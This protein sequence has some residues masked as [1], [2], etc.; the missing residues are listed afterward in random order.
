MLA[1]SLA[2]GA[3]GR[4]NATNALSARSVTDT[5]AMF[6][7]LDRLPGGRAGLERK[8]SIGIK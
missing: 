3:L 8:L 7:V 5:I 4:P 1:E 6:I 2:G